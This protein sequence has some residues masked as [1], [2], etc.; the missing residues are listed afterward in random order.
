MIK[1]RKYRNNILV[2]QVHA[3]FKAIGGIKDKTG[4]MIENGTQFYVGPFSPGLYDHNRQTL[5][6]SIVKEKKRLMQS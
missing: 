2:H 5:S 3:Y 1:P 4:S 6:G